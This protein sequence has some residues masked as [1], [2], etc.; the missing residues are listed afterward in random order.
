MSKRGR[1]IVV[2]G[3]DRSGKS[4]QCQRLLE[5]F[6]SQGLQV[7]SVKFPDRSTPTG[8]M[9]NSYLTGQAQQDDHA[10]HLIFS[11]N[12]WEAIK[13][14]RL[15]L[16]SGVAVIV[17]RYSFSGAVYSAAK[18]NPELSLEWAWAPEIGLLKPDLVFFLDIS[19]ADAAKRGGYGAERYEQEGMQARVR[20]LFKELF[21]RLDGIAIHQVD[22]GR[23]MDEVAAEVLSIVQ[24]SSVD[25]ALTPD[26]LL[27]LGSLLD[28]RS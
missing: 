3:L 16:L 8:Q 23:T 15:A 5:H 21:A 4:S 24:A 12:R 6:Q 19:S 1:L 20:T 18:Q 10:I 22:A 17:D 28:K 26:D 14:I 9:I 25:E 27:K 13:T 2:E 7:R 11:A